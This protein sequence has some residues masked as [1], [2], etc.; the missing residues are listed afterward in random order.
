VKYSPELHAYFEIENFTS[1]YCADV[2]FESPGG[3]KIVQ[4]HPVRSSLWMLTSLL[5]QY[6]RIH[7]SFLGA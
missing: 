6:L 5:A 4:L 1:L 2:S 3:R 7:G